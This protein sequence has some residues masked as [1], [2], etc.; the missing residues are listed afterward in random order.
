MLP[1][2]TSYHTV[3]GGSRADARTVTSETLM[4]HGH[5]DSVAVKQPMGPIECKPTLLDS[6]NMRR[7]LWSYVA[8]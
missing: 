8:K 4:V 6:F 1:V 3:C 7:I 2:L 5:N